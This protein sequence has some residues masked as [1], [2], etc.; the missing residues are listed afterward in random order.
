MWFDGIRQP[1]TLYVASVSRG[2]DSTAMLR[3]IQLMGW[4]LDAIVSV[5]VWFDEETP[6][7]LPPLVEFKDEWDAKC[8]DW[9]GVPVTRRHCKKIDGLDCGDKATYTNGFYR[10]VDGYGKI[11]GFSMHSANWCNKLKTRVDFGFQ[12]NVVEYIG[13]AADEPLRIA[14]HMPKKEKVMPLVQIDWDEDL[15]GLEATYMDMLS[16]TYSNSFRDGCWFCHKQGVAQLRD[17]RHNYPDLWAKLLKLDDDS[18]VTFHADG[19]TVRDFDRRFQAEDDGFIYPDERFRW[20]DIEQPQMR[21][22]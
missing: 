6:A 10:F 2:K 4:P 19:H 17:L 1:N 13:I 15:C 9:F 20:A 12:S 22:F 11:K 16:P 14:R 8:L 3:A 7:E 18:P 5:D 21:W